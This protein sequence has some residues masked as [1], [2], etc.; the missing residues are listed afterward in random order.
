MSKQRRVMPHPEGGWQVKVD[1]NARASSR[2]ETQAEAIEQ[3]RKQARSN[4]EE[5]SIHGRNNRIRAKD[6]Y[7][8]DPRSSK[9]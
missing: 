2:H 3:A 9:G 8:N 1:G 6:S 4:G 5:L 7:G